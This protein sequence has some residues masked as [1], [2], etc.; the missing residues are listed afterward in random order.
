MPEQLQESHWQQFTTFLA[1]RK[2]GVIVSH[3]ELNARR[4]DGSE[5]PVE[6]SA[7]LW[8]TSDGVFIT[9]LIRDNTERKRAEDLIK[10]VNDCLLSF[11]ADPDKNIQIIIE[12]AGTIFDGAS[13]SYHKKRGDLLHIAACMEPPGGIHARPTAQCAPL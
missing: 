8:K 11:S 7:S 2:P 13:A 4:K 5:F 9:S 10:K 12:A 6:G 3:G 1:E